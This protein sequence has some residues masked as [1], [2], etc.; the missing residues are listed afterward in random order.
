MLSYMARCP[1]NG[2]C[3]ENQNQAVLSYCGRVSTDSRTNKDSLVSFSQI[4]IDCAQQSFGWDFS[5][6]KSGL[7]S[8]CHYLD[9]SWR[10]F[11]DRRAQGFA[12][13]VGPT[14]DYGNLQSLDHPVLSIP[15]RA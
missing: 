7:R 15:C 12:K 2:V 5:R 3:G 8:R 6:Y 1:S 11:R 14:M 9:K 13:S 4:S 10:R